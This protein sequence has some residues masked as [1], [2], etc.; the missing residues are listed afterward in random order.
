MYLSELLPIAYEARARMAFCVLGPV[1]ICK[2]AE[3]FDFAREKGV[4]IEEINVSQMAF[5]EV[6]GLVMP[7][8]KTES[9]KVYDYERLLRLKD[10]DILFLDE[11]LT[12]SEQTLKAMLKL[13]E[14]RSFIS[15]R[16][17]ADVLII[18]AANPLPSAT[19]I[20]ISIRQRFHFVNVMWNIPK[21]KEYIFKTYKVIVPEGICNLILTSLC[22]EE[23]KYAPRYNRLTPRTLTKLLE[24]RLVCRETLQIDDKILQEV[25]GSDIDCIAMEWLIDA[26][27]SVDMRA[28][29]LEVLHNVRFPNQRPDFDTEIDKIFANTTDTELLDKLMELPEWE[30]I[31]AALTVAATAET[32]KNSDE[33]YIEF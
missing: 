22:D 16:K 7:D 12:G 5:N 3:I 15:G 20:P 10:G 21:W 28:K 31:K 30:E 8:D 2:T 18:A 13:I 32:V 29:T 27:P 23:A 4:R 19:L 24:M 14:D 11:L 25:I 6:T 33:E 9:M 17:L 1:G 26:V